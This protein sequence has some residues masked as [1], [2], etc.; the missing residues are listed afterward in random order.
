LGD[1][2][3]AS[4]ISQ[5]VFYI[6]G[7]FSMQAILQL[8]EDRKQQFAALPIFQYLQDQQ[9]AP[10]QRLCWLPCLAPLSL[11][12][13]DLWRDILYR[14]DNQG[15]PLQVLINQH[16]KEDANHWKWYIGDIQKLGFLEDLRFSQTLDF[17]WNAKTPQTRLVCLKIAGLTYKAE[18]A[19]VLAAIEALEA[20]AN[21][22]FSLTAQVIQELP[23]DERAGLR[24]FSS[25]HLLEDSS[26]SIFDTDQQLV[27]NIVLSEAQRQQAIAVVEEIFESFE[28]AFQEIMDYVEQS[29]ATHRGVLLAV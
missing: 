20:T 3:N 19:V 8:V 2:Q 24:Y 14:Q 27:E 10:K 6:Y 13:G 1:S 21:V 18:P 16:T 17:L 23:I 11:G 28:A 12:F 4:Y 29:P 22:V 9:I 25:V 5:F 15:N 26:H 7:G